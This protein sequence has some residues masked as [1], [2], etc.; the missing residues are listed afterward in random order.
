MDSDFNVRRRPQTFLDKNRLAQPSTAAPS[1]SPV[2]DSLDCQASLGSL[3]AS[4]ARSGRLPLLVTELAVADGATANFSDIDDS[5]D[6]DNSG[7][8]GSDDTNNTG[9]SDNTPEPPKTPWYKRPFVALAAFIRHH[10]RISIGIG[11]ACLLVLSGLS[12]YVLA[13]H[14]R[15]PIQPVA[16]VPKAK[17][18]KPAEPIV[19]PLTGMPVTADQAKRPVT[20]IMI[21]NTVFARPQSGLADAGVVFEAIAEAGITRFLALH[22][23]SEPG[24]IGPVRSARPYYVDWARSFDAPLAH[25]GGSP[26][27]L[28]KIKTDGAKDLDQFNNAGAYHRIGSREAPH[29]MYTSMSSLNDLEK[30]KGWTSSTFTGF[31]RKKEAPSPNPTA[32]TIDFNISGPTYNAHYDYDK[33]NNAYFRSEGG[34]PHKDAESGGQLHPKV[35]VGLVIPYSLMSDGYHSDYNLTGSGQMTVFQ[36]G[37]ATKGTWTRKDGGSQYSFSDESGKP[38]KLNA[39]QT[40]VTV[41]S[42]PDAISYNP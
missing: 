12:A 8:T 37:L 11:F 40:W 19:S 15:K 38:L 14:N 41:V 2:S 33:D 21:E 39:G 32:K 18:A 25:V 23:E 28:Q 5:V 27:A 24:N 3:A 29:N 34:A 1:G 35:V 4:P 16:P 26:D 6:F 7:N 9:Q 10:P 20:G 42:T 30:A 22:Q 36:D 31:Q 17:V 13:Q